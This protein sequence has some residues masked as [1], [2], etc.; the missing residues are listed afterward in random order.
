MCQELDLQNQDFSLSAQKQLVR[1]IVNTQP[2]K[3]IT[4]N[5]RLHNHV[6]LIFVNWTL[7]AVDSFNCYKQNQKTPNYEKTSNYSI[8]NLVCNL[9]ILMP[10]MSRL[11]LF[12]NYIAN[13]LSWCKPDYY[14]RGCVW[15]GYRWCARN[16]KLLPNGCWRRHGKCHTDLRL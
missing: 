13:R 7:N 1:L 9:D 3:I 12:A 11:Y 15:R 4:A 14:Y 10:K 5:K 6:G 2:Q 16:D 8:L